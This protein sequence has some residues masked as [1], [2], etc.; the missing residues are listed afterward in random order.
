MLLLILLLILVLFLMLHVDYS[1][2]ML[3]V[4]VDALMLRVNANALL[5][6]KVIMVT[7]LRILCGFG[8]CRISIVVDT[9]AET[10]VWVVGYCGVVHSVVCLL[11][12]NTVWPVCTGLD[13]AG[14][15]ILH[16]ALDADV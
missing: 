13:L 8:C 14:V 15:S 3:N 10:V 2:L 6:L 5:M 12:V 7:G 9:E 1:T 4:N 11:C 16:H